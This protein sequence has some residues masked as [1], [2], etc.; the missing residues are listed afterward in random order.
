MSSFE[1]LSALV[2]RDGW[3]FAVWTKLLSVAEAEASERAVATFEAFLVRFPLCFG[4]WCKYADLVF[5]AQGAAAAA[6]VYERAVDAVPLSVELWKSYCAFLEKTEEGQED[7]SSSS[8]PSSRLREAYERAV[9]AVGFDRMGGALWDAYLDFEATRGTPETVCGAYRRLLRVDGT[10]RVDEMWHRFKL[11]CRAYK[12][13]ELMSPEDAAE[14]SAKYKKEKKLLAAEDDV[15][16]EK[17]VK[18]AGFNELEEQQR[19]EQM[20]RETEK[21]KNDLIHRR[22]TRQKFEAGI[23]RW[24]FH[25]KPVDDAQLQNWRDYLAAEIRDAGDDQTKFPR[26][27]QLFERCLVPCALYA[28]F[29]LSYALWATHRLS[30][31]EAL[32]IIARASTKFLPQRID[33]LETLA[34]FL[35]LVGRV[36]DARQVHATVYERARRLVATKG[37][38]HQNNNDDKQSGGHSQKLKC[39]AAVS[40]ANFERRQGNY[41]AA[42]DA[43]R[44]VLKG[45]DFDHQNENDDDDCSGRD[46]VAS[47]CARFQVR[48]LRDLDAARRTLDDALRKSPASR[49]LWIARIQLEMSQIYDERHR[50]VRDNVTAVYERGL[51]PDS[52]LSDDAKLDLWTR[53]L[54]FVENYHD[55]ISASVDVRRRLADFR[56]E[57]FDDLGRRRPF[58]P[59][60][61]EIAP[62]QA[63]P[64]APDFWDDDADVHV[65]L[66]TQQQQ[67]Q[68]NSMMSVA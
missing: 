68:S 64:Q 67:Q 10:G 38:H 32:A 60:F 47:H 30:H 57:R 28:E 39:A 53:Y 11:L 1:E 49:K 16:R 34:H 44:D 25:A 33:L 20:L 41:A 8:S 4:Y 61:P 31:E 35:E 45:G 54:Y 37:K 56:R 59:H 14:F 12:T 21:A 29:W 2:E 46:F 15:E 26:V 48:V 17:L 22:V 18:M 13:S 5:Q 7:S 24:Y 55:A 40:A 63:T 51:A 27:V 66:G 50:V 62:E 58:P 52:S 6:E 43:Y 23:R 42:L 65:S 3:N 19:L 9:D 36:D